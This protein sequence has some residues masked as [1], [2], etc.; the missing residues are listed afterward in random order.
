MKP[1][2]KLN[3]IKSLFKTGQ[4]SYD[5]AKIQAEPFIQKINSVAVRIA[6]EHKMNPKLISFVGFMR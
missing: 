6:K 1:I 2:D 3:E 5:E 4:I